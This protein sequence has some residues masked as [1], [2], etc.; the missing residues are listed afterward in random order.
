MGRFFSEVDAAVA[1]DR[2]RVLDVSGKH[3]GRQQTL[4]WACTLH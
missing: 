4:C 3:S 1:A 2:A